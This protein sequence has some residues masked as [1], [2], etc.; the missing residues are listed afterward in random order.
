MI[1]KIL[2]IIGSACFAACGVPAALATYKAKKSIGTPISVAL[3]IFFG[4]L[5]MYGYLLGTY[6]FDLLL[7]I[8]YII[9][10]LSWG[11]ISYYHYF[12]VAAP[13]QITSKLGKI[14]NR[15]PDSIDLRDEFYQ[16]QPPAVLD[17]L[18]TTV[19][20][21]PL[22]SPVFDQGQVGSC[23]GNAAAGAFEFLQLKELREKNPGIEEFDPSTYEAA[24]RL[25]IY[26]N[27]RRLDHDT[28]EDAGATLRDAVKSLL[29]YGACKEST[30]PYIESQAFTQP[31]PEAYEEAFKH[32]INKYYRFADLEH[33]K[34][35]LAAGYP[36]IFGITLFESFES[37]QV[38]QNGLVPMPQYGRENILGGHAVMIVGYDDITQHIIVRN[39][40]GTGWGDKGYFYLP[41]DY[42]TNPDFASD[43]WTI[44]K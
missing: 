16:A 25:F 24:S 19:D 10:A 29:Y 32:R 17:A 8:N 44:R 26:Y 4:S 28:G 13:V 2:G 31:S 12:P 22:C 36:V 33:I 40:W 20:L 11:L 37:D 41:Y 14:Y 6:G 15:K 30:W 27:E 34:H 9:E 39:S 5:A 38:A 7:T 43:F 21:R 42:V 18:P 3:L 1:T 35:S 23:T